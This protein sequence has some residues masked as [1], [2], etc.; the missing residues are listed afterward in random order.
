MKNV[1][2]YRRIDT[3]YNQ[4]PNPYIVNLEKSLSLN[5]NIINKK[6]NKIGV[7]DLFNYLF[8]TDIFYF[9]WIESIPYN[10]FGKLQAIFFYLFLRLV[11][12][13]RKKVIWTL[14]NKY[15]H[16]KGKNF[17]TDFM[18]KILIDNSDLILTHS[19]EGRKFIKIKYP[20]AVFKVKYIVHPMMEVFPFVKEEK[21]YDFL[22]WGSIQPYKGILEFLQF[23]NNSV[24]MKCFKILIIGKCDDEQYNFSILELLSENITYYNRFFKI[25][26]IAHF[27]NQ[28]RFILFTYKTV[29]ILSSGALMDSIRMRGSIIGPNDGAFKDLNQHPFIHT[30]D[31]IEELAEIYNKY[32]SENSFNN[33]I[34]KFCRHNT[35]ELFGEKLKMQLQSLDTLELTRLEEL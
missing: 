35:W 3:D 4:Y 15:S 17:W 18:Y 16:D 34:T 6:N 12:F 19:W 26:D 28:S 24:E 21:K 33:E 23:V 14:H 31:R 2:L 20:N 1:F 27:V 8:R 22:I 13:S 30:Y 10:R 32:Q 25:S 11:K 9:N 7:F 29:S 5:F